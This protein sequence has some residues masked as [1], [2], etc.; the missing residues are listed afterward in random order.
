MIVSCPECGARYRL[1]DTAIPADGRA[2]RCASCKHR[3]FE[4]GPEPVAII[5]LRDIADR[6]PQSEEPI[7]PADPPQSGDGHAPAPRAPAPA[8]ATPQAQGEIE[9]DNDEL[10]REHPVLKTLLALVLGLGFSAGAAAMWVPDLP[11]IDVS[12]VPWLQRIVA[13]PAALPGSPL[14]VRFS[15]NPQPVP[16]GRRTVFAVTGSI[17][18]PT[19]E[20]HQPPQLEGRL[21]DPGGQIA[22]RWRIIVPVSVLLPGQQIAFDASALGSAGERV[23][24][25]H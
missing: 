21:V 1:A 8:V 19:D 25:V 5:K 17:T 24:I 14:V 12:S 11:T 3:W 2:M 23:V 22:Y 15:V 20:P 13:T 4:L 16:G 9:D 10:R 18:N 6:P 7:F